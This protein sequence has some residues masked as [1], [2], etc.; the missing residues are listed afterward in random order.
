MKLL[1]LIT[2]DHKHD[3]GCVMLYFDFPEMNK[4][5]YIINPEDIYEDEDDDSFGLET[6]PHVTLLYGLHENVT[7]DDVKKAINKFEYGDC[8]LG[9]PS[10]FENEK[11]DVLKY[12]VYYATRGGA[13]LHKVNKELKKLPYTSDFPEYNP[14]LTIAYL[15]PGKGKKYTKHLKDTSFILNPKYA[16]YSK[17]DGSKEKLKISKKNA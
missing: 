15:N 13:F 14:H 4:I 3:Y 10:I 9:N 11:Y 8:R 6:E 16:V 2:E 17:V 7:V 5:Q 12:D 1:S